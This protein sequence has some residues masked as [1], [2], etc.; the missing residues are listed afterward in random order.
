MHVHVPAHNQELFIRVFLVLKKEVILWL[1][2]Q[3]QLCS[4]VFVVSKCDQVAGVIV[5]SVVC[6]VPLRSSLKTQQALSF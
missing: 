4:C 3:V 5:T 2:R 6:H 1:K